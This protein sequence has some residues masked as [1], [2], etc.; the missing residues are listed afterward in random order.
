MATC[1]EH[2]LAGASAW[3]DTFCTLWLWLL[4]LLLQL[5]VWSILSLHPACSTHSAHHSVAHLALSP[6][7]QAIH[8]LTA[9]CP[10]ARLLH[11]MHSAFLLLP[12]AHLALLPTDQPQQVV[13]LVS[14]PCGIVLWQL[15]NGELAE[16]SWPQCPI[17]IWQ[18]AQNCPQ[19]HALL[20]IMG[21]LYLCL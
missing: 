14:C 6:A 11:L 8:L 13:L 9:P 10:P 12:L 4:L 20:M 2:Q 3:R 5:M 18:C 1:T 21:Y 15:G 16:A 17:L 19:S 7:A